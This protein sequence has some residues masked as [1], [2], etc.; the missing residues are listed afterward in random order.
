MDSKKSA[1]VS[2]CAV[3]SIFL[4]AII[5][6]CFMAY[7]YEDE[8]VVIKNPMIVAASGV[9]VSDQSGKEIDELSFSEVKLGLKPVTGEL[10]PDTK[11]PVTVDD[12]NGSEGIFAKFIVKSERVCNFVIKN[13]QVTG[14]DEL[15]VQKERQNIWMSIAEV[16]DSTKN[17]QD[18]KV[19]L[20][21][22][23]ASV[24][25]KEY[26]LLLWFSSVASPNFHSTTISFDVEII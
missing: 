5:G 9:V 15:D 17:F 1:A 12:K 19:T 26:T 7:K 13:L 14:N 23:D 2:V 10:D 16:K 24:E 25:G 22:L 11:I 6:S 18:E 20:G 4:F 21:T 8:K 3:L